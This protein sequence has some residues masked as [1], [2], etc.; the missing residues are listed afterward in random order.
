MNDKLTIREG[1]RAVSLSAP[2]GGEGRGEAGAART[3]PGPLIPSPLWA[4]EQHPPHPGLSS[5]KKGGEGKK[6]RFCGRFALHPIALEDA[7]TMIACCGAIK[8]RYDIS[9][10]FAR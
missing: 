2:G 4:A 6:Y 8:E 3:G 1:W 7:F 9:V 5:L 10:Q